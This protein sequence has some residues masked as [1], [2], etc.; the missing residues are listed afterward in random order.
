MDAYAL[1]VKN[2]KD[3]YTNNIYWNKL[4]G[5]TQNR[6]VEDSYFMLK[7]NPKLFFKYMANLVLGR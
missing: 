6:N 7:H 4:R 2:W 1:G 5:K 3:L